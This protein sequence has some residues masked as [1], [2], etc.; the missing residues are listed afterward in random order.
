MAVASKQGEANMRVV[1]AAALV[2]VPWANRG[3][4]T[5]IIADRPQFRLSLATIA[6]AGPFSVFPGIVRHL[7]LLSGQ[8]AFQPYA[9]VIDARSPP[10]QFPG[11]DAVHAAPLGGPA[12]ALNLMVPD[13]AQPLHLER[14]DGGRLN[15]ALAIFAC[16]AMTVDNLALDPHDTLFPDGPVHVSGRA[17]VVR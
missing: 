15:D 7:A 13:G 3:G 16:E 2:A 11:A 12:L 14:C 5:R 10:L 6:G 17:L 9:L 4:V 1:R 8:V